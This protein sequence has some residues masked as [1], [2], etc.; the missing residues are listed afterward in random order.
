M[1]I[2]SKNISE[3]TPYE[4]NPRKNSAAVEY[5]AQSISQ[6]G[7]KVP[8]VI[9]GEGIVVCGHTRLKAA[10]KLHL[11]EVPCVI[12]DDLDAEQIKAFRLADNKVSERAE[13][14]FDLLADELDDI[15]NIDMSDFGFELL[16]KEPKEKKHHRERTISEYNLELF[17]RTE[18]EG[19]YQM[20]VIHAE[21][22][23]PTDLMGFNYAL[24]SRNKACGIHCF[25]DDYQFERLW[26]DPVKY[27][28]ALA[29]YE[30]FLSPDFSLYLDMPMAMKIWNVY[31]SRLIGQYMQ[32]C[33]LTVIPTVSWAEPDTFDFCFDGI[34]KN[35]TV[36][37]STVGVKRSEK[38]FKYWHQGMDEMIKRLDPHT[39]LCYGGEVEYDY[40]GVNTVFYD[41]KVTERM[42][43]SRN[44]EL[45]L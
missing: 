14:D 38:G 32:Q 8:I 15:F 37:I 19:F 18:S 26:T 43:N 28:E 16:E 39:I 10:K 6:F 25:V 30:C 12:A 29:E 41:N 5:V 27:V 35:G 36:A 17:D 20:P 42:K 1:Q 34:E 23:I 3:L 22:F 40:R 24:S 45:K 21:R 4:K 7:F 11:T 13:W 44:K 31:R 33:G 2:V 9:D